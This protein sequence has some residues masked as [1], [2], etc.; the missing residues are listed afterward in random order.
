[1]LCCDSLQAAGILPKD[2]E[3]L[4]GSD[5]AEDASEA[6][7]PEAVPQRA[8][9]PRDTRNVASTSDALWR[10]VAVRPTPSA[11]SC[12]CGMLWPRL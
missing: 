3:I 7:W 12:G 10:E 8:K 1:M 4:L 5:F 9:D 2:A 6:M 11:S